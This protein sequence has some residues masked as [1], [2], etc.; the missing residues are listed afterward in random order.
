MG[1]TIVII[2]MVTETIFNYSYSSIQKIPIV[3]TIVQLIAGINTLLYL[4]GF[5]NH[6][7]T[8]KGNIFALFNVFCTVIIPIPFQSYAWK[9]A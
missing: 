9:V 4:I 3:V 2:N 5:T 6:E 7:N 8:S 1:P